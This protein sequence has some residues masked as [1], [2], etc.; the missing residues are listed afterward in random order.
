[1]LPKSIGQGEPAVLSRQRAPAGK[2]ALKECAGNAP[3]PA[4]AYGAPLAPIREAGACAALDALMRL[5]AEA[6]ATAA[7][8]EARV[9][10]VAGRPDIPSSISRR[11]LFVERA[12]P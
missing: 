7:R 5:G 4:K 10:P 8:F 6:A 9:D 1:M 11:A 12:S 3:V 2:A